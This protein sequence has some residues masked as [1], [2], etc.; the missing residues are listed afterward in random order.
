MS[1]AFSP[2]TV[3]AI[4]DRDQ[5]ACVICGGTDRLQTHHRRPRGMGGTKARVSASAAN[6]ITV[7]V[8]CHTDLELNRRTAASKGWLVPQ[9]RDPRDVP[10]KHRIYGWVTLT[11]RGTCI[12]HER[13]LTE[14]DD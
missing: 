5:W 13:A 4:R 12:V 14:G 10:I 11:D 2:A 9:Y 1:G 3:R 8:Y 7:C 6:G